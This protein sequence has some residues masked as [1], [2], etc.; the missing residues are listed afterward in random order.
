MNEIILDLEENYK[1]TSPPFVSDIGELYY[2]I[3]K[4]WRALDQI[5]DCLNTLIRDT[6]YTRVVNTKFK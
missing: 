3:G 4:I 1:P 2:E 5:T 6:N